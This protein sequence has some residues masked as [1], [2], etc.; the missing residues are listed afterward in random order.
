MILLQVL[1]YME[2]LDT[3]KISFQEFNKNL[4]DMYPDFT[5]CLDGH[6]NPK[7]MYRDSWLRK[8]FEE[9][10]PLTAQKYHSMILGRP[11]VWN[12]TSISTNIK[13]NLTKIDYEKA[14]VGGDKK[15]A[16][17][18]PDPS[19]SITFVNGSQKFNPFLIERTYQIP[20]KICFTRQFKKIPDQSKKFLI[21]YEK[22]AVNLKDVSMSLFLH[23]PGQIMRTIFGRDRRVKSVLEINKDDIQE[24][25]SSNNLEINLSQ[26][27]VV[28]GRS[29]GNTHCN[30]N[31]F[32]D[33][34]NFWLNIYRSLSCL[35]P[36]WRDTRINKTEMFLQ[37]WQIGN[38]PGQIGKLDDCSNE[39]QFEKSQDLIYSDNHKK[40]MQVKG[41]IISSFTQP[42]NEMGINVNVKNK[43][44]IA[45][46]EEKV[47][48]KFVYMMQKYQEIKNEKEFSLEMLWSSIGGFV[49]MFIG[50][51]M[52]QFLDNGL[53]WIMS[54]NDSKKS[55]EV[56]KIPLTEKVKKELW[57][58][59]Q[60]KHLEET[61]GRA[62]RF[63]NSATPRSNYQGSMTQF[64]INEI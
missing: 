22:L 23:Y 30:P 39:S 54:L 17:F 1:K 50:Y 49:G 59:K 6:P 7:D 63:S 21:S 10:K 2:N 20:G 56:E 55:E 29:D 38:K 61:I 64:E 60:K 40:H 3:P 48:L 37:G 57:I 45:G 44:K 11:Y 4:D 19:Y 46:S 27:F 14:T 32:K 8:F 12:D 62:S 18:F 26:M 9:G 53:D 15:R 31:V 34:S 51:S 5:I 33:D 47:V 24:G 13:H 28:K 36:Y 58:R 35:P 52:L 16:Y 41:K 42:C 25:K 43:D